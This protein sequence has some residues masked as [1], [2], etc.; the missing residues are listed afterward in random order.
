MGEVKCCILSTT[1][2]ENYIEERATLEKM[3]II[4]EKLSG[5]ILH[6]ILAIVIL[7]ALVMLGYVVSVPKTEKFTEFYI[8]GLEGRAVNYPKEVTAGKEDTVTIG[9]INREQE[10][11]SYWVEVI[12]DGAKNNRLGPLVL[13]RDEKWEGALGFTPDKVGHNQK[14]E[15]LLYNDTEDGP[16]LQ[17][18]YLLVDVVK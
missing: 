11:V 12:V 9:I 3:P 6:I 14:V 15:F 13:P 4:P 18:L 8:L 7:S 16:P 5:K 2:I 10:T 17:S 1:S